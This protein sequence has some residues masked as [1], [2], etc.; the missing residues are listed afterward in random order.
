MPFQYAAKFICG[1]SEKFTPVANG[2]YAT[3]VNIHNPGRR[4]VAFKYKFASADP[5]KDGKV[6]EFKEGV[7]GPDGA[8][9]FDCA[10]VRKIYDLFGPGILDGFFVIESASSFDVIAAYTTNDFDGKNVPAIAVERVFERPIR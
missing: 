7:I 5:G 3:V 10:L 4:K 1:V 8:Q 2:Q 9:Y 6:Y